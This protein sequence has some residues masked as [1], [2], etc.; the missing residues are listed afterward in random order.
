VFTRS[1]ETFV[2]LVA[3]VLNVVV[4]ET[5]DGYVFRSASS[6]TLFPSLTRAELDSTF[7]SL[8]EYEELSETRIASRQ[9]VELAVEVGRGR[10]GV[11]LR[12]GLAL[13]DLQ[14][15]LNYR[16]G[17][18]SRPYVVHFMF[19]LYELADGQPLRRLLRLG[20]PAR[21]VLSQMQ[22]AG[23]PPGMFDVLAA[24][25]R[26]D[27]LII[28]SNS[29]KSKS[30]WQPYIDSFLF[31]VTYNLDATVLPHREIGDLL[32]P[33]RI[34][35]IRRSSPADLDPPRRHYLSD[36]VYHYQLGVSSESAMLEYI[37]YYHVLEHFFEDIY[38]DDLVQQVQGILT[39]AS[40]S[41]RRKKDIGDLIKRVSK[42]L[43]VR[44]EQLVINERVALT[45]TLDRYV[46]LVQ[47][48][49]D[50]DSYDATLT[51]HY[52][53]RVVD[54][55]EG[56]RVDLRGGNRTDVLAALCRRVYKTRN[57]VVHSKEGAKAKFIPFT[58]DRQLQPEL[59]LMRF[60]V[61]Q[62]IQATSTLPPA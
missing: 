3:G 58:H 6:Q 53:G 62:V 42:A 16:L 1:V 18:A 7:A 28:S 38:Q 14:S 21:L 15:G 49:D 43:Q 2:D 61:E 27:T 33:A 11:A 46:D 10:T 57:A 32:R 41:Y 20:V 19:K 12:D 9:T 40:F 37:S 8:A 4:D 30:A 59:P 24:V 54:F 31:H 17:P 44:D 22:R 55:S 36:L 34:E 13:P 51:A 45:L 50:L 47:L 5:Q 60:I 48:A 35:S 56:D 39:S 52:K 29:P 23:E 25:L 26:L